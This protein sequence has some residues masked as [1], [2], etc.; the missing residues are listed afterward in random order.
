LKEFID[1]N[2]SKEKLE[3]ILGDTGA[4]LDNILEYLNKY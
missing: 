2:E 3:I 1:Q 4:V